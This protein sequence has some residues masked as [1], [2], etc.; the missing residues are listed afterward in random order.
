MK[1]RVT[2]VA[3]A[4]TALVAAGCGSSNSSSSS[5]AGSS[6]AAAA[7][8]TS[9]SGTSSG[10]SNSKCTASIGIEAPLT[11]QVAVLGQ[12]QLAFAQLAVAADNAANSTDISL[13]QGDTQLMPAQATTVTQQFVSNSKIVGVIGPAGSQEVEAVGPLFG[14]GGLAFITGSATNSALTTSGKNPTF[15]RV[16]SR[17]DVQGPQDAH[18]IVNHLHPKSLMIVDDQ[19]AYSTGLVAAMLPVFKAAGIKVDHES[20][21][22]KVTD[23]SSLVAKVTS[24]TSVVVL[25]WQVAANGQQFGKNLAEQHKKAV[26]VGTDGLFSPSSF[27]TNGAYVS[28]FGPDINFIP[29]D[30]SIAAQAKAK[31]PKYGTFGPP[32]YAAT[33]VMDEAIASACKS[34][35]PSRSSVLAA[36]KSTDEPTSILGQPIKFDSHGDLVGGKFFLFKIDS[37]GKY[38]LIPST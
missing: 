8:T 16:V 15:F 36:V 11:G 33:H 14:R 21:S 29:A 31:F 26:I 27:T 34:G 28:S 2:L 24:G 3:A 12:E 25:P 20:V 6:S 32:I 22:Q 1:V 7:A 10:A 23:F 4:L 18:Y 13:V 5:S 30:K 9:S 17:D 37:A 35:T 38:N 19:E